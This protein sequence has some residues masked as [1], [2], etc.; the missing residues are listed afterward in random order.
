MRFTL[1]ERIIRVDE[2]ETGDVSETVSGPS[3][4][5]PWRDPRLLALLSLGVVFASLYLQL[6]VTL[7]LT[8]A[9]RG[10]PATRIGL[11]STLAAVAV[12][13]GQ[14]LL[15]KGWLARTDA[16]GAMSAGYVL[17]GIGLLANG[18]AS[19]LW[20]FALAT[21]LWS[22]GDLILLGR[23]YS[24]VADISP[25]HARARYFSVYGLCWG[26]AAVLGPFAGTQLLAEFGPLG[27]WS[28]CAAACALLAVAQLPMRRLISG[29]ATRSS[30]TKA[31]AA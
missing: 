14:P 22:T 29:N 16:F 10:I 8:L 6:N 18:F 25:E 19:S 31:L 11:L 4:T 15:T 3:E 7:P 24:L 13:L 28:A 23:A 17:L 1:P 21:L 30:E 26:V 2:K 9:D 27:L 5:R 12:L 20:Q